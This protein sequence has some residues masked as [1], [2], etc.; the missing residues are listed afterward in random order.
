M[1]WDEE[2]RLRSVSVNGQ[3]N[4]YV[5]DAAGERV[6]KGI[7]SGQAVFVN[8][9]ISGSSGGVGNFTVYASPY[10]VVRSGEHSNHYFIENQRIATRLEHGW[11]QQ[12][13]ATDA[14]NGVS[15]P[16][17]EQ[18]I[19]QGMQRDQQA[20]QGNDSLTTGIMGKDPRGGASAGSAGQISSGTPWANA[21]PSNNGN[22]YAYGHYKNGGGIGAAGSDFLYFYHPDHLGSTSYVTDAA[23]EVYQ[24]VEYFAFGETFVEE[25]SNTERTPYLFNGKELDGETGLY[26]Y[27]ARYY[28]PRTSIWESVD[29]LAEK[30]PGWS[31]YNAMLNNPVRFLDPNGDS[32]GV[33]QLDADHQKALGLF[34]HTKQGNKFLA[35]YAHKGQTIGG[36]KFDKDGKYDKKGIN[37]TYTTG[38]DATGSNTG[39]KANKQGGINITVELAKEGY[40][41]SDKTLNLVKS[42]THESFIH[43][44]MFTGDWLDDKNLNFSN[45]NKWTRDHFG[46]G[47]LSQIGKHGQHLEISRRFWINQNDGDGLWPA[48][49]FQVLKSAAGTLGIKVSDNLIKNKMWDFGGSAIDVNPTTGKV[50]W[51]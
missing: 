22:H 29:P 40:G 35:Q 1:V 44:D 18:Q 10:L 17:K 4:S 15:W 23:G 13:T 42:I 36:V 8:G 3:L 26:Y 41:F 32:V 47:P 11:D 16:K 12:V 28:D 27:G 39:A 6:L 19:R 2:N 7:G 14:G 43:A 34:A 24:H 21:N 46:T 45:L 48:Q 31:P 20:L 50:K 33:G 30:Y 5:Y 9:D 51:D 49:G 37:L 25:H 38:E